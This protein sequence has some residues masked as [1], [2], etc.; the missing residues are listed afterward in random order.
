MHSLAV[1]LLKEQ[2]HGKR[3]EDRLEVTTENLP[4]APTGTLKAAPALPTADD[5]PHPLTSALTSVLWLQPQWRAP[6]SK[7]GVFVCLTA[8]RHPPWTATPAA[9]P[10]H[11]NSL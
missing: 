10:A 9:G 1:R 2:T 7:Y 4:N 5:V 3:S 6:P 11:T 8:G